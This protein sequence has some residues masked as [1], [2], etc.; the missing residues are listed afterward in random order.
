MDPASTIL[1]VST[2]ILHAWILYVSY[3]WFLNNC[4]CI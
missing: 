2:T 4:E 3:F 1:V